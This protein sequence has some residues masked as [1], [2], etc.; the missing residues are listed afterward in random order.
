MAF[1]A[2]FI[3]RIAKLTHQRHHQTGSTRA[4]SL[5]CGIYVKS[6]EIAGDF[7]GHLIMLSFEGLC[8]NS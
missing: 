2:Y 3:R 5:K 8:V 1:Y 7:P 6:F 4:T